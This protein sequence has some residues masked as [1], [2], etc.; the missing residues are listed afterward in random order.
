MSMNWTQY[1][2]GKLAEEATEVAKEALKCQQQ[3]VGSPYKGKPAIM[4]L[5]H[6]FLEVIAVIDMLESRPDVSKA[7][8]VYHLNQVTGAEICQDDDNYDITYKK[9]LRLCYYAMFAYKSGN[10]T[11]TLTEFND[12]QRAAQHHTR[13]HDQPSIDDIQFRELIDATVAGGNGL[14]HTRMIGQN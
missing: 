13:I 2:L 4:E 8:G 9:M 7:L 12:V 10:L 11:L 5:R 6:E 14:P 1:L 3:G